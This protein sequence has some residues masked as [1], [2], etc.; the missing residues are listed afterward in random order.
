MWGA[1]AQAA[2]QALERAQGVARDTAARGKALAQ[3]A[4]S[5]LE[6]SAAALRRI[7]GLEADKKAAAATRVRRISAKPV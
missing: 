5:A 6:Q 2:R 1:A 4:V 7:A 3:A